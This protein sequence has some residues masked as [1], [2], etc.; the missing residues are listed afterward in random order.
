[1]KA[2]DKHLDTFYII[3]RIII[4]VL[5]MFHGAQKLFGAFGGNTLDLFTLIWFAG[6]I[7]FFGGILIILGVFTRIAALFGGVTMIV[8]YFKVHAVNGLI[9][10][11]NGGELALLYRAAFIMIFA[12]GTRK[13]GLEKAIFGKEIL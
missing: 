5:F 12:L 1:M 7:E 9:P 10:L 6:I 8:A 4:G 2:L 13:W 11:T 3:F